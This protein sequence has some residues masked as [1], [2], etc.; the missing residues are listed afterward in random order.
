MAHPL[1]GKYETTDLTALSP[2]DRVFA[3]T[4]IKDA[5]S[6][7]SKAKLSPEDRVILL[8]LWM[9]TFERAAQPATAAEI[10]NGP[11]PAAQQAKAPVK[12][13]TRRMPSV[14]FPKFTTIRA[15]FRALAILRLPDL[16][17]ISCCAAVTS[18]VIYLGA[19]TLKEAHRIEDVKREAEA[20]VAW[21][22]ENGG[23]KR[24]AENF[25]PAACIKTSGE[26]WNGCLAALVAEGGPL[27]DK[28]NHFDNSR[29]FFAPKCDMGKPDTVGTIIIERGA[30]PIGS[31]SLAYS[32]LD[33]TESIAKDLTL[34][35][36]VCGR[37]FHLIKV[38]T[39]L[40]F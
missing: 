36:I 6:G 2:E 11:A 18:A 30:V 5:L 34:R 10:A 15:I 17:F 24:A 13:T 12:A 29:D 23:D 19:H 37:G 31:T 28:K 25:Q 8:R 40:I 26:N 35:V 1:V 4:E 38:A 14:S 27:A 33:G 20:L 3:R 9:E 21:I 32:A 39:D 7:K 16:I 22:K